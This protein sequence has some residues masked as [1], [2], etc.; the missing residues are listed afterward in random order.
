MSILEA[1]SFLVIDELGIDPLR[2]KSH[3]AIAS[4]EAYTWHTVQTEEQ[5]NA[6]L[7]SYNVYSNPGYWRYILMYNGILDMFE[8]TAGLRIKIPSQQLVVSVLNNARV[9]TAVRTVRI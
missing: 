1:S 2:D 4:I 7:L 8:L 6:P 9:D 5:H 3:N